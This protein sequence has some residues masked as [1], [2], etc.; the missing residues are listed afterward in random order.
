MGDLLDDC[1]AVTAAEVEP[2]WVDAAFLNE[3]E[4]RL[5]IWEDPDSE[6][7]PM[8]TVDGSRAAAA[9][10]KNRPTRETARHDCLVANVTRRANGD[11]AR[12]PR[13]RAGSRTARALARTPGLTSPASRLPA[14]PVSTIRR[15]SS[16]SLRKR[17][18]A[19]LT[20]YRRAP[21]LPENPLDQ[22]VRGRRPVTEISAK[23]RSRRAISASKK[24]NS[25]KIKR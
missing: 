17:R 13:S 6:F 12:R 25:L 24:Y 19:A 20:A 9:G 1:L 11:A 14:G 21:I 5:P 7:S 22:Q 15:S 16:P 4:V 10:L 23:M 8:L 3:Q 2:V 18:S